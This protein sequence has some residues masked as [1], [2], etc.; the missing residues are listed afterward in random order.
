MMK[1]G[2]KHP[3]LPSGFRPLAVIDERNWPMRI[4]DRLA[5]S[6]DAAIALTPPLERRLKVWLVRFGGPGLP[7]SSH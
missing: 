3:S 1:T 2:M 6:L 7:P 4:T 5:V